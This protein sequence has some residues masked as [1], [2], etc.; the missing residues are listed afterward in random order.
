[1]KLLTLQ[2]PPLA[3][4]YCK[5]TPFNT[6]FSVFENM[7]FGPRVASLLVLKR[8]L[9]IRLGSRRCLFFYW[10]LPDHFKQNKH[11]GLS[12]RGPVLFIPAA[13][14]RLFHFSFSSFFMLS[15]KPLPLYPTATG[16]PHENIIVVSFDAPQPKYAVLFFQTLSIRL[17][18]ARE[19]CL[20]LVETYSGNPTHSW[21]AWRLAAGT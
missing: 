18:V 17:N 13:K 5:P 19:S 3:S 1:M 4:E 21:P 10:A 7:C 20:C 2:K 16:S 8:D 15:I 11:G 9:S 14:S 12:S 6:C